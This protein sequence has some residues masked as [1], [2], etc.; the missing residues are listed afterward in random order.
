ML[1]CDIHNAYLKA[2]PR[3]KIYTISGSEFGSQKG[4]IM[5]I[6]RALY[7]LKSSGASFRSLLADRLH[8]LGYRTMKADPDVWMR[9]AVKENGFVYYE[10]ILCYVDD[11]L[12]ISDDPMK[13]M[14]CINKFFT[15]KGDKIEEPDMYLEA[16]LSKIENE[17]GQLCWEM[18]SEKY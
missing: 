13:T 1:A 7:G 2:K 5:L 15:I 12:R 8:D 9:P 18:S 6:V 11:V 17:D 16:Q 4:N 14:K 10:Y 3:E